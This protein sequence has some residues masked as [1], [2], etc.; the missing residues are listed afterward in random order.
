MDFT[1]IQKINK[2]GNLFDEASPTPHE[3]VNAESAHAVDQATPTI[4]PAFIINN[5]VQ[6]NTIQVTASEPLNQAQAETFT[7]WTVTNING[8]IIYNVASAVLSGAGNNIVTLTLAPIDT[9]DNTT[10]ITDPDM[11]A[12]IV[13]GNHL[14][15][16]MGVGIHDRA[17]IS[18][19]ASGGSVVTGSGETLMEDRAAPTAILTYS[20][21]GGSTYNTT[22]KVKFGDTLKIKATF[23]KPIADVPAMHI[24][25][26]NDL[27]NVMSMAKVSSTVYTYDFVVPYGSFTET[28]H[29]SDGTDVAGNIVAGV[30]TNSSFIIDNT[31]PTVSIGLPS[32]SSTSVGPI[33]YLITYGD[34]DGGSD[35][36]VINLSP[37]DI[38]LIATGDATGT[39]S[40]ITGASLG[41]TIHI[42]NIS[43]NGTLGISIPAGTSEDLAGN[44]DLGTGPSAT[45]VVDNIRPTSTIDSFLS[46]IKATSRNQL[47]TITYSESMNPSSTP[48]I[49]F[50]GGSL[51]PV[52]AGNWSYSNTIWQQTFTDSANEEVVS[53]TVTSSGATD[54]VGNLESTN[55]NGA[56]NPFNIDTQPPAGYSVSIDQTYINNSNK[57]SAS[58]TFASAD[59]GATYN[60]SIDDTNGAFTS[61]ITG[62]G[63]IV[64]TTEQ[65]TGIDVSSLNDETLILTVSLTD[66]VGNQGSDA[67]STVVKDT[68][69]P[70]TPT[71][72]PV[73]GNYSSAQSITLS[74]VSSSNIY[75][76]VD[77]SIPTCSV[78]TLYSGAFSISVSKTIKVIGCDA[79]GNGTPN[80]FVF[81]ITAP[82]VS[83]GGGSSIPT[84]PPTVL[85]PSLVAGGASSD[86]QNITLNFFV[87][88][89][90]QMAIS[91]DP[92]FAKANWET[93]NSSKQFILSNNFGGK[94]VYVKFMSKD[95]GV[96]E[97]FKVNVNFT[98]K[99][100]NSLPVTA[101]VTTFE[102]NNSDSKII[103]VPVKKLQYSPNS[104]INYTYQY[105]NESN[106]TI[107]IKVV[108]Q[109]I[110]SVGKAV[111]SNTAIMSLKAG[112]SFARVV[113]EVLSKT[114]TP[115][116]YMVRV[117]IYNADT[118][119]LIDENSFKFTVEKLKQ[120]YFTL[121]KNSAATSGDLLFDSTM[122][123]KVKDGVKLPSMLELKYSYTN[124]T[125]QKHTVKMMRELL[126]ANGKV[127]TIKNGKWQMAVGE[128]DSLTFFQPLSAD[129]SAGS[130]TVRLRAYDW[131]TKELLAENSAEF[132]VEAK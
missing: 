102:V 53:V 63:I 29:L 131:T 100:A 8:S 111:K 44:I 40:S 12:S 120:K 75:Y 13:S 112:K 61:P 79:A 6:P 60:Y 43:G 104:L 4:S 92:T 57:T 21:D 87:T 45:F 85:S 20:K 125:A 97:T 116:E 80:S 108:R 56:N 48:V 95:G 74:S 118:S 66:A 19:N 130:Y 84:T 99:N 70:T 107:K 46:V 5:Q 114:L 69:P 91:E 22:A 36:G 1:N 14:K 18:P 16:T 90:T 123:S 62:T 33:T 55:I 50:S 129:L 73:A 23:N 132:M 117:A 15:V 47:V 51:I 110:N 96:T 101:T 42:S 119:K 52:T 25:D 122:M 24:A 94:I 126:D 54:M 127:V 39:I 88:N 30:P 31:L 3:M 32:V 86:S 113:S 109:L 2:A 11:D 68:T 89:T 78:G 98:D 38:T 105:K 82:T 37:S 41:K 7:N 115:G 10:Y 64:S 67:T 59:I 77:G 76:T 34:P 65:I 27:I 106:K 81:T 26:N 93:Y 83:S 9:T 72:L 124:S 58:F 71:A 35:V 49:G 128:K 121:N 103:I 17:D 28:I